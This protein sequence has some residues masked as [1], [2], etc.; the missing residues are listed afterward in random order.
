MLS[1]EARRHI[2]INCLLHDN[3]SDTMSHNNTIDTMSDERELLMP[4]HYWEQVS[5]AWP[6]RDVVPQED[7]SGCAAF[8]ALQQLKDDPTACDGDPNTWTG[9]VRAV[10]A[11]YLWRRLHSM[12]LMLLPKKNYRACPST[13]KTVKTVDAVA[14]ICVN[15]DCV[16]LVTWS[17]SERV[18]VRAGMP[19]VVSGRS[20]EATLNDVMCVIAQRLNV[21]SHVFATLT[22]TGKADLGGMAVKIAAEFIQC[23]RH[24]QRML[25]RPLT[26]TR[27]DRMLALRVPATHVPHTHRVLGEAVWF[28]YGAKQA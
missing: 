14:E 16:T 10:C 13:V 24:M 5:W 19:H 8:E 18:H 9:A 12:P 22:D 23:V 7:R 28:T 1:Q 11:D 27:W 26:R 6:V 20:M 17:P 15:R 4:A 2:H 21:P 25:Q 3:T